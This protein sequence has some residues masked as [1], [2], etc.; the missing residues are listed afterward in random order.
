RH[1]DPNDLM[2]HIAKS[3]SAEEVAAVADDLDR[4]QAQQ[5]PWNQ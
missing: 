1:N 5:R 4:E 3:L 2:G